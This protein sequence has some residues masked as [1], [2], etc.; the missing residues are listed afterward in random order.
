MVPARDWRVF[1]VALIGA[2]GRQTPRM[3]QINRPKAIDLRE[4]YLPAMA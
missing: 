1:R 3:L 2:L 4:Y